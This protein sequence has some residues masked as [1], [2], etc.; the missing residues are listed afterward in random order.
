[1]DSGFPN[2]VLALM[3]F[4][5]QVFFFRCYIVIFICLGT[6]FSFI[7]SAFPATLSTLKLVHRHIAYSLFKK[8][9]LYLG[10]VQHV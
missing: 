7:H 8:S 5:Q 9:P 2:P 3:G 4:N 6:F 10:F 1:M